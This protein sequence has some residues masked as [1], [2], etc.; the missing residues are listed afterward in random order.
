[1]LFL[2]SA[3]YITNGL[4]QSHLLFYSS[5]SILHKKRRAAYL[6]TIKGSSQ[7]TP[8]FGAR[9]LQWHGRSMA[10]SSSSLPS[11]QETQ[12]TRPFL[13]VKQQPENPTKRSKFTMNT[14]LAAPL[15]HLVRPEHTLNPELCFSGQHHAFPTGP[16]EASGTDGLPDGQS[17]SDTSSQ[18]S[19]TT[20]SRKSNPKSHPADFR[21]APYTKLG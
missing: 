13:I 5:S 20:V 10:T 8:L 12:A 2:S 9:H 6:N 17:E 11:T 15:D 19:R 16:Q 3:I 4:L 21:C 1:M 14:A 18:P 7:R